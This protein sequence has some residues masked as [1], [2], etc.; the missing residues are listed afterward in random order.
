MG[1][2]VSFFPLHILHFF[3]LPFYIVAFES[4]GARTSL[5]TDATI[6]K[7]T[8][9]APQPFFF[10]GIF[11]YSRNPRQMF[12]SFSLSVCFL[13]VSFLKVFFLPMVQY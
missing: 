11:P 2:L 5:L 12:S 8:G 10:G 3:E 6:G 13:Q 1:V 7:V 4:R 9:W